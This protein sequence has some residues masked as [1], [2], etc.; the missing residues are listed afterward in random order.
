MIL[1]LV[2]VVWLA[3][4]AVAGLVD[5]RRGH[6]RWA[7]LVAALLGPFAIPLSL[8]ARQREASIVPSVVSGGTAREGGSLS[9]LVGVD[10]SPAALAAAEAGL[11]V[12]GPRVHRV[13]VAT[14]LDYDTAEPHG[15]SVLYP[16][17]WDEERV[18]RH[19]LEAASA[20]LRAVSGH[21]PGSVILAGR[22]AEALRR[23]ATA[24]NFDLIVVGH[25]GRGLS[26]LVLGSCASGLAGD[27]EV[28]VL[29]VPELHAA[30]PSGASRPEA[31]THIR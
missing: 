5:A 9:V 11:A 17:E 29:V 30:T 7:W 25:R 6:W 8:A 4:G 31:R 1:L 12:L 18:A 2:V 13:V 20:R 16:A 22:P 19:L 21:D 26:K 24:E 27:S 3:V 10:G 14:V 15:E 23:Y 28:P